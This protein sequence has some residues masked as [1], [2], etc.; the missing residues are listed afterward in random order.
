MCVCS[1][2]SSVGLQDARTPRLFF[3]HGFIFRDSSLSLLLFCACWCQYAGFPLAIRI[4]LLLCAGCCHN[5]RPAPTYKNSGVQTGCPWVHGPKFQIADPCQVGFPG[6]GASPRCKF[7]SHAHAYS[8][9]MYLY[10]HAHKQFH[11]STRVRDAT[12]SAFGRRESHAARAALY[13][14]YIGH[15]RGMSIV[16]V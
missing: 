9:H 8:T 15:R 2:Q 11:A 12:G 3:L 4:S 5:Y 7:H 10:K 14:I 6:P 1:E 13:R 16:R